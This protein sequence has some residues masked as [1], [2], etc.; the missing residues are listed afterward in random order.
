[1]GL[2]QKLITTFYPDLTSFLLVTVTKIKV[3]KMLSSKNSL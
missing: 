3:T 1:M 2:L